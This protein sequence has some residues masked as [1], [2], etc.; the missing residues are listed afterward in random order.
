MISLRVKFT[1]PISSPFV[2]HLGGHRA[3]DGGDIADAADAACSTA[4]A[5]ASSAAVQG[6]LC[7]MEGGQLTAFPS[8]DDHPKVLE[9][10]IS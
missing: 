10:Q 5:A 2:P 4:A 1:K 8:A 9:H 3:G 7:V 6:P